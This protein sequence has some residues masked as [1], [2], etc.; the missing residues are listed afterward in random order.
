MRMAGTQPCAL[1][2]LTIPNES[3]FEAKPNISLTMNIC[4]KLSCVDHVMAICCDCCDASSLNNEN[5]KHWKTLEN[6]EKQWQLK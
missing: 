1:D 6:T 4:C 3:C 5:G 2:T